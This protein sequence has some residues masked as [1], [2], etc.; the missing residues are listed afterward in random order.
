[1]F[2][3][4]SEFLMQKWNFPEKIKNYSDNIFPNIQ[5]GQNNPSQKKATNNHF[6]AYHHFE[7]HKSEFKS[8]DQ[9]SDVPSKGLQ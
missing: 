3:K 4:F 9:Q 2:P 8:F 6:D 7:P 5:L 1:M